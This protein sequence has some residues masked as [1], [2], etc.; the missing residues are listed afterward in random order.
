[1]LTRLRERL[2]YFTWAAAHRIGADNACPACGGSSRA[3]KTK[4]LVTQLRECS[5]CGLRFRV[6]KSSPRALAEFYQD[7]YHDPYAGLV[8]SDAEL[9]RLLANEFRG[10]SRDHR[11]YLGL[12]EAAGVSAGAALYDYGASWGYGAWQFSRANYR[13]VGYEVSRPR[14]RFARERL[15]CTMIDDPLA[16][17]FPIDCMFSAHVMEHLSDPNILWQTARELLPAGGPLIAVMPNGNP[18]GQH[19][20]A[21]HQIWGELHPLAITSSHLRYMAERHGFDAVILSDAQS[22]ATLGPMRGRADGPLT[23]SELCVIAWRRA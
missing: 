4:Y 12:L 15:G 22:Y 19:G 5:T 8:P 9:A 13:V 14:A 16:P 2:R 23:G 20:D 11:V 10:T 21:Y 7:D 17:P 6:P 1:M 18:G 3:V